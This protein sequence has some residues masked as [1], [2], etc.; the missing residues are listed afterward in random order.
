MTLTSAMV[1][2]PLTWKEAKRMVSG[3]MAFQP[4]G[5]AASALGG[6]TSLATRYTLM[7]SRSQ[8]ARVAA[9]RQRARR[10]SIRRGF[11][12][13]KKVTLLLYELSEQSSRLEEGRMGA[14]ES[15]K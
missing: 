10:A 14:N 4:A 13:D 5:R 6:S 9:I 3:G 2:C 8:P 7:L 1:P 15:E 12:S 11:S